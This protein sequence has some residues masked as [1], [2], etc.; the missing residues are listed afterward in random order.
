MSSRTSSLST[1]TTVPWTIW[2][3]STSTMVPSMASANDMPRSSA[4]TW[5]GCRRRL[6]RRCPWGLRRGRWGSGNRTTGICFRWTFR[7]GIAR[8]TRMPR[9]PIKG[10]TAPWRDRQRQAP[11][12]RARG[13]RRCSTVGRRRRRR[14]PGS[15]A[16]MASTAQPGRRAR[17]RSSLG[18]K[19]RSTGRPRRLALLV[20]D[21]GALV[22]DPGVGVERG[23]G[24]RRTW[25]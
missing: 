11:C 20:A 24:V 12:R 13:T 8:R 16:Q 6:R 9:R 18:V 22:V 23:L 2:P 25:K 4:V 5:R 15:T 19:Q 14:R 17:R 1:L 21:L 3:S 10:S 7:V